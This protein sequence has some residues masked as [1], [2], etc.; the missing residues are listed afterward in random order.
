MAEVTGILGQHRISIASVMQH[1]TSERNRGVVPL[2]IM[3]HNAKA[4]AMD[5]ALEAI[6][7]LK[8]VHPGAICMRVHN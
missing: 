5:E 1:E 7:K 4:G 8:C 3:T 2:V 6:K